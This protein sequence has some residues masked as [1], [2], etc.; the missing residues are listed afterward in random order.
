[1]FACCET[2]FLSIVLKHDCFR[3]ANLLLQSR[4]F[5]RAHTLRGLHILPLLR[6]LA[7]LMLP[8]RSFACIHCISFTSQPVDELSAMSED[9]SA[10]EVGAFSQQACPQK[11]QLQTPTQ[12]LTK[13]AVG[14]NKSAD[15]SAHKKREGCRQKCRQKYRHKSGRIPTKVPTKVLTKIWKGFDKSQNKSPNKSPHKSRDKK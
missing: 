8:L 14:A 6:S 9:R 3:D 1:M 11:C 12:L 15:K 5:R 7:R 10:D 4:V 2:Q 13:K